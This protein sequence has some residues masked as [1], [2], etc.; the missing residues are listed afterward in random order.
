V[1]ARVSFVPASSSNRARARAA[2]LRAFVHAMTH[3]ARHRRASARDASSWNAASLAR[4]LATCLACA[5]AC[6]SVEASNGFGSSRHL[7]AA[8]KYFRGDD[9]PLFANKVGP[10]HNP[11]EVRARARLGR[12][13]ATREGRDYSDAALTV[14]LR[15]NARAKTRRRERASARIRGLTATRDARS[16]RSLSLSFARRRTSITIIRFVRRPE[17]PSAREAIWATFWEAIV[18]RAYRTRSRS[19]LTWRIKLCARSF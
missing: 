8:S 4:V 5:R 16:R 10:F 14:G 3:R 6:A 18:S 17:A 2:H 13:C 11:S 7:L 9:V 19:G 15:E 1:S 12:R